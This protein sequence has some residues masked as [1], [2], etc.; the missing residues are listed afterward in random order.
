MTYIYIYN[1]V[2]TI[3]FLFYEP[4]NERTTHENNIGVKPLLLSHVSCLVVIRA[5]QVFLAE[6]LTRSFKDGFIALKS[7]PSFGEGIVRCD[8]GL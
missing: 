4:T 7:E 5:D 6:L 1:R 8:Q 2:Y 3:L